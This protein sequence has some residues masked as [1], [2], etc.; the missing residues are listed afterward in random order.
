MR[1]KNFL[2]EETGSSLLEVSHRF[3]TGYDG[4]V[5]YLTVVRL[6]TT[7][8]R[9]SRHYFSCN[10]VSDTTRDSTV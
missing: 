2:N 4:L 7:G 3:L 9:Y 1:E 10:K 6:V 8:D 5:F